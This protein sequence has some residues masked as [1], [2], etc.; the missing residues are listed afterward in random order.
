ML[1]SFHLFLVFFEK[2]KKKK[3]HYAQYP[4]ILGNVIMIILILELQIHCKVYLSR[5]LIGKVN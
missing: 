1:N 5:I 3:R 2:K 4:N